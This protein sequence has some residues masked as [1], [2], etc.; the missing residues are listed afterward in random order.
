VS[1]YLSPR[2]RTLGAMGLRLW[3]QSATSGASAAYRDLILR[4]AERISPEAVIDL[5]GVHYPPGERFRGIRSNVYAQLLTD[6]QCVQHAI[7][8]E[9]EGYDAVVYTS[10]NDPGLVEARS[11]V[12]IPVIGMCETSVLLGT[13]L[14]T[15]VGIIGAN[16]SQSRIVERTVEKERLTAHVACIVPM[17]Q[18]WTGDF[19]GTGEDGGASLIAAFESAAREAIARGADVLVSGEGPVNILLAE[20]GVTEV[21][22]VRVIDSWGA[23]LARAEA[24][25]R[26]RALAGDGALPSRSGQYRNADR[27]AIAAL[28]GA[29]AAVLVDG[30]QA[31]REDDGRALRPPG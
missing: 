20:R 27:G 25:V 31:P 3:H 29:T 8:A 15:A 4:H 14:G 9:A 7:Q 17:T 26:L 22:G 18:P 21:D 24:M 5:H 19:T 23:I 16:P 11:V 30:W 10:F 13:T 12:D 1:R 6:I 2:A 28:A